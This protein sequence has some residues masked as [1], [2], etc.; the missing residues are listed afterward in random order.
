MSEETETE[1]CETCWGEG[2]TRKR[3]SEGDDWIP[4]KECDGAG[5]VER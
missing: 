1:E 5:E 4:C 3:T 2:E